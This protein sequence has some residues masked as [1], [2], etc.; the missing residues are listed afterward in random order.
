MSVDF[1]LMVSTLV[2]FSIFLLVKVV[3]FRIQAKNK[4]VYQIYRIFVKSWALGLV[5]GYFFLTY[6]ISD[7]LSIGQIL[8][9]A[10]L[11]AV[12]ATLLVAVYIFGIFLMVYASM[13]LEMLYK[14]AGF[15]QKGAAAQK[16]CKS[17]NKNSIIK[18][19]LQ[20]L[21]DCGE[22]TY[23]SGKYRLTKSRSPLLV[24]EK[25][26]IIITKLFPPS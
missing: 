2:S 7:S 17:F 6:L 4:S 16:L 13:Y 19:R 23:S 3:L 11:Y 15:G 8:L 9:I 24:R 20:R 10:L 18:K 22:L 12:L 14:V 1:C 26:G 25:I 21:I 5:L